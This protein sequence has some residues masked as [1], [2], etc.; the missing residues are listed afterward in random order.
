[1][2]LLEV[3]R[4]DL[5]LPRAIEE[6]RFP[7]A[8]EQR[9]AYVR[10]ARHPDDAALAFAIFRVA[11]HAKLKN[12]FG[13]IRTRGLRNFA[14]IPQSEKAANHLGVLFFRLRTDNWRGNSKQANQ[15]TAIGLASENNLESAI[16][17]S[18]PPGAYTAIVAGKV[19]GTGVA[20]VEVYNLP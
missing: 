13:Q 11:P 2:Q 6:P 18:F 7:Q 20:L 10:S 14:R 16:V 8:I 17:A 5:A 3:L 1:M 4:R 9:H 19:G 12:L 15:L